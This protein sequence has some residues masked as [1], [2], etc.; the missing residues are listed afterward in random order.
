VDNHR[1]TG[2]GDPLQGEDGQS[3]AVDHSLS[4]WSEAD[5]GSGCRVLYGRPPSIAT[6]S[7]A[8][9]SLRIKSRADSNLRPLL[10]GQSIS[11]FGDYVAYV[12]LPLFIVELTGSALDLGLT[13]ASETVPM[14]FFGIAAGVILDRSAVKRTLIFADLARSTAFALLALAAFTDVA[15]PLMVFATAFVVGSMSSLFDSGLQAYLPLALTEDMLV[16]ANSR[17]QLI[18]TLAFTAGAATGGM[19]FE[20]AGAGPAFLLNAG[21]FLV[22]AL[23]LALVRDV[24]PRQLGT[25][26]PFLQAVREGLRFLWR[27]RRLRWATIGAAL[28]NL[29]FAPLEVLL[30]LFGKTELGLSDAGVGWL[31]ALQALIGALAAWVAPWAARRLQL[32]RMFVVGM[33]VMGTG[34]LVAATFTSNFIAV[35][36]TGIA[37]GG[38][39]WI[40]VAVSTLRHRLTPPDK[41]GRVVSASR[42]LSWIGIPVGAALGGALG[43]GIGLVPLF[44]AASITVIVIGMGLAATPLWTDPVSPTTEGA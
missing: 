37:L 39:S 14:L 20:F 17:L 21:T 38:V 16:I 9:E 12:A 41:L 5:C 32:G 43:E 40:N 42:T 2:Y 18:R 33:V 13:A 36:P 4:L 29:T 1:L 7:D 35:I 23:Y 11:L 34:W 6:M 26:Q 24:Y 27:D 25:G 44:T 28:A 30:A 31:Y 3:A 19:L 8:F 10:L 22:S 15:T